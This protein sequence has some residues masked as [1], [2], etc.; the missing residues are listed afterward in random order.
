MSLNNRDLL[1]SYDNKD[2]S[3]FA[4]DQNNEISVYGHPTAFGV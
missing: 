3:R 4:W 2:D 1:R